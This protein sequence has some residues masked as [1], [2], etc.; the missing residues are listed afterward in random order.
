VT[1]FA[2]S[3]RLQRR[4]A[5]SRLRLQTVLGKHLDLEG[6]ETVA[7]EGVYPVREIGPAGPLIAAGGLADLPEPRSGVF[8]RLLGDQVVYVRIGDLADAASESTSHRLEEALADM[9]PARQV[10]VDLRGN[11][12]GSFFGA[13]PFARQL[14]KAAP[15]STVVILS[16]GSPSL[17]P[18]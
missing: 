2:P 4:T 8:H 16:T 9:R 14:P 7:A 13:V 5:E 3:L 18:W 10:I 17:P 11:P 6:E 15:G 1:A 12:G